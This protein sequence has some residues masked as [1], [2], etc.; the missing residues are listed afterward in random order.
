MKINQ[1]I[2]AI[3]VLVATFLFEP[4]L[5]H[6]QN[7]TSSFAKNENFDKGG[8]GKKSKKKAKKTKKSKH[9]KLKRK[10]CTYCPPTREFEKGQFDASFG[11]GL[12]PTYLM[13]KATVLVPPLSVGVDYRMSEKFSLGLAAGHSVS[14]SRPITTPEGILAQWT[15][16]HFNVGLKPGVHF[17]VKE[18]WDFYG[19][20]QIGFN[21]SKLTGK[22]EIKQVSI[23][24]INK[25]MGIE[26]NISPSFFGYTGVR[27]VVSPKWTVNTEIGFGIS[28]LNVG[29]TYL[30]GNEQVKSKVQL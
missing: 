15:N 9:K 18:N 14:E 30:L 17:T 19:G 5:A 13:D 3:V 22:T 29:V 16:S 2:T 7:P 12:L 25:H 20:F 21:Y 26:S 24:E 4:F 10:F 8:P 11:A 27:Y 23:D 6:A 1:I 28:L